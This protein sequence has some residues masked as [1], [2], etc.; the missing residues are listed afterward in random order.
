MQLI[1]TFVLCYAKSRFSHDTA[2]IV[3]FVM[4]WLILNITIA[5]HH[6]GSEE[7]IRCVFDEFDN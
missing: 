1:L 7:E 3:L 2:H 6:I 4:M 5:V